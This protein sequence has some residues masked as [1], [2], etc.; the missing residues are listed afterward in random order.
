MTRQN[1][2]HLITHLGIGGAQDNTL[3]T[4]RDLDRER[5]EVHLVAGTDET[6]W[7]ERGRSWSDQLH[8]IPS[9]RHAI[10]P[11][12]DLRSLGALVAL[13]R[14]EQFAIVHTHSS[15][16]GV[17][18][19]AAAR[20][21]GVPIVVHTVHGFAWTPAM[22]PL[23]RHAYQ[24]LERWLARWSD[25]IITVAETNRRDLV[26][27][28]IAPA[29]K[30]TTIYSG[31]DQTPFAAQVDRVATCRSL[32]LQPDAPIVGSVAR[33]SPQKAPLDFVA[34][35]RIVSQS[36]PEAQ[37]VLVGDGP[38]RT[39][40]EAECRGMPNVFVLGARSDVA[41]LLPIFDVFA[42]ASHWEG[43]G[44]ALTEA[45]LAGLPVAVTAVDGIPEVVMHEQT[46][47]LAPPGQ[48]VSLANN[49]IRL[50]RDR[51][52]AQ[53]LGQK[54]QAWVQDRFTATAMVTRIDQLYQQLLQRDRHALAAHSSAP[55]SPPDPV[56]Q[57]K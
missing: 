44:R 30:M 26:D 19:R 2:L 37:F 6:A 33:L 41:G 39:Q 57:P 49:I 12:S 42:L 51:S 52:L 14:R 35:A 47:L 8:L 7:V 28:G 38:L 23:H 43:L 55:L 18:G 5:Y 10:N 31:I 25:Q 45:L 40:V 29:A 3:I 54:G 53:R 20:L 17:L 50:L 13:L 36:L 56:R 27:L 24:Q 32:G 34:A 16:A 1:I 46:G 21:A 15:K 4:V 22:L 11:V 9:L 48:P